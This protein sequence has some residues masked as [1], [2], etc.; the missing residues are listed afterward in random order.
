MSGITT[1]TKKSRPWAAFSSGN[2]LA[3]AWN[4][5]AL[6]EAVNAATGRNI[7]LLASVERVAFTAHVEVQ[8]VPTVERIFM[9]LPQEQEAVIS[10][11]FG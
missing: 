4:A 9:T 2:L 1:E 3:G 11:Y 8:V 6:V 7:T 10:S 5:E